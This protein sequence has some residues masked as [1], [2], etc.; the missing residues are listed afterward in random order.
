[1]KLQM[2]RNGD[3][4]TTNKDFSDIKDVGEV[5]HFLAEIEIIKKELLEIWEEMQNE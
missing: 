3:N 4:I 2:F 1:M 5:A